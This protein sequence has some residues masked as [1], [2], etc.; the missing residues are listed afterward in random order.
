MTWPI[1]WIYFY[2]LKQLA[3]PSLPRTLGTAKDGVELIA[4]SGPFGPYLKGGKYNI[5]IKDYDPYT[6]SF[7]EALPLYE[8]KVS[9]IIAD[10][11]DIMIINGAYGPYVK[12]PGR[13]NNVKI[14]KDQDPKTITKEMAAE[15]LSNKPKTARH[16]KRST[17]AKKK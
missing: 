8:A 16:A 6:I 5:P 3:L 11:G 17:K 1:H 2:T 4:A 9:S 14:P 7:D 13:R 10:W 12:G 15:M